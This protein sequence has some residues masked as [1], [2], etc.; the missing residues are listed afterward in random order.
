MYWEL[1][2]AEQ[3]AQLE[4]PDQSDS[5]PSSSEYAYKTRR[6]FVVSEIFLTFFS[7]IMTMFK[8]AALVV[9]IFFAYSSIKVLAGKETSADINA[10]LSFAVDSGKSGIWQWAVGLVCIGYGLWQQKLRRPGKRYDH[11]TPIPVD[12]N[13]SGHRQHG[14][15]SEENGSVQTNGTQPWAGVELPP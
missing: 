11:G 2:V 3:N 14:V 4:N 6:L 10:V 5:S 13:V 12:L 7:T 15:F 1:G 8:Y 9:C